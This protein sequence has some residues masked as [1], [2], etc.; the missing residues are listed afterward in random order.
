MLEDF[1]SNSEH[2]QGGG[3]QKRSVQRQKRSIGMEAGA[4]K[5][6]KQIK[7]W[8]QN[9]RLVQRI[10]LAADAKQAVR[11]GEIRRRD[12]SAAKNE[13]YERSDKKIR[14]RGR[15]DSGSRWCV[16]ELLAADCEKAWIHPG[17]EDT[18]QKW[19]A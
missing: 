7:M 11:V 19:C 1:W 16:S 5:H 13:D 6:E 2:V 9:V 4:H 12:E 10:Q 15:M 8:G 14:S 3:K 18:M 17:R